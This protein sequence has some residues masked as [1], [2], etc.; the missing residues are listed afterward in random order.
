MLK[1]LFVCHGMIN[2]N[3]SQTAE[4]AANQR[5]IGQSH[6]QKTTV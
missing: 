5:K 1:I 4:T 2:S 6:R 3:S